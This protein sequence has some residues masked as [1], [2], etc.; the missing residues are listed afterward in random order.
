M[1]RLILALCLALLPGCS[2]PD[3]VPGQPEVHQ[4]EL[5][6]VFNDGPAKVDLLFVVDDSASMLEEQGALTDQ[7]EAMVRELVA[8][9]PGPDGRPAPP[10]VGDL[11]VAV[12]TTDL[13]TQ[14]IEVAGCDPAGGGAGLLLA[15]GAA[16]SPAGAPA[17]CEADQCPWFARSCDSPRDD[18]AIWEGVACVA[19]VGTQGCGI[20]QPLEASLVAL[21]EQ[22]GPGRPN[23]GFLREDSLLAIVY[24]TDED[25]C[26]VASPELFRSLTEDPEG[27]LGLECVEHEDLLH[28][29]SRYYDALQG[30]RR[31][32][33]RVVVAVVAG[34]PIDG[35]WS[36]G[37][38]LEDLRRSRRQDVE[39][40][41]HRLVPSCSSSVALA[42]P[43]ARLAELAYMFGEDGML[44]S[45]CREDWTRALEAVT[46][47]LQCK[48]IGRC[49][50]RE[51]P[52]TS[53]EDCR[54]I[55]TL[56]DDRACPHPEEPR[57][58]GSARVAGW[59]RDLG[60]DEH[61]RRRCEALPSDYDDDGLPDGPCE[62]SRVGWACGGSFP[63]CSEPFATCLE[64][65]FWDRDG[66]GCQ[67]GQLRF[68][69]R[70]V[71]AHDGHAVFQCEQSLCPAERQCSV[72]HVGCTVEDWETCAPTVGTACPALAD[73]EPHL[74]DELL[75]DH[76]GCCHAGFHCE[77][78][79]STSECVPDRT[80]TC[81]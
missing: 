57:G 6:A 65:W 39:R 73:R 66:S 10:A 81:E 69:S 22:S 45:I 80:T 53:H 25:D 55:E 48:L 9:E 54:V 44:E 8:P 61:G 47:K 60:L 21:T 72:E 58:A 41:P 15:A 20:E 37:D 30:L 5:L 34:V 27:S 52:S 28:P 13:G 18:P 36:P 17:R 14:G 3:L 67:H 2:R 43:P 56:S 11:H 79:A 62:A 16:C 1:L 7:I 26:S 12:V 49:I 50:A 40:D 46:R 77:D 33:G 29:V 4:A 76:L 64:G 31:A 68:T 71:V 75:I 35:S 70:A 63:D 78:G 19:A 74:A 51:L 32:R 42:R 24:I 59:H 23:E 38:E